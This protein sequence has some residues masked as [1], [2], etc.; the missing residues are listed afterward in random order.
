MDKRLLLSRLERI[1]TGNIA[2]AM[3][4]LGIPC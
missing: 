2:D 1:Q 4:N 3:V